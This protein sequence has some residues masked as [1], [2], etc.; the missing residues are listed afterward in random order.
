MV[1]NTVLTQRQR[2]QMMAFPHPDE[3][4]LIARSYLFSEQDIEIIRQQDSDSNQ[5][6][7]ALHLCV[8]RYPGRIWQ[9]DEHLPEY[10]IDLIAEQ[11]ALSPALLDG[12]Q[13]DPQLRR[14]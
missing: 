14:E 13:D 3:T 2:E 4:R 6:A 11:L 10:L 9:I 5:F 1:R 8:L 12:S 7:F